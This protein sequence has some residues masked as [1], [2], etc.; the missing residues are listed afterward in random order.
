MI[1]LLCVVALVAIYFY[2]P[3]DGRTRHIANLLSLL[4]M[5]NSA[6]Y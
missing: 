3:A 6:I 4:E 1:K 5:K 2:Q